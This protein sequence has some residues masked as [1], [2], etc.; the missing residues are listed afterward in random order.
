[1]E[2]R[3]HITKRQVFKVVSFS[4]FLPGYCCCQL[5]IL[6]HFLQQHIQYNEDLHPSY[7]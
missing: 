5:D 7:M 1:L 3:R 2:Y 6:F 4:P